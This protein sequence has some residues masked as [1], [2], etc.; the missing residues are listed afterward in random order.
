MINKNKFK[1]FKKSKTSNYDVPFY[2]SNISK[3]LNTYK[4]KPKKNIV[5][6]G[7]I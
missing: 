3:V 4:W 5:S 7:Y 6:N 1:I 2:I